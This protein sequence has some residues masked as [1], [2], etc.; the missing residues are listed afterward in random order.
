M[1][2]TALVAVCLILTVSWLTLGRSVS[3]VVCMALL[4]LVFP[5]TTWRARLVVL[6]R[7]LRRCRRACSSVVPLGAR[8]TRT[9][10]TSTRW[11]LFWASSSPAV[12]VVPAGLASVPWSRAS[13]T[14]LSTILAHGAAL[15]LLASCRGLCSRRLRSLRGTLLRNAWARSLAVVAKLATVSRGARWRWLLCAVMVSTLTIR[16]RSTLCWT[17]L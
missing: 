8:I 13:G 17:R 15:A 5:L 10:L 4:L 2:V 14:I 9:S 16:A 1:A 7:S 12:L 6:T 11:T 3:H